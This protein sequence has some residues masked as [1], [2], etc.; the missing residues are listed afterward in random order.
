M[1]TPLIANEKKFSHFLY[2]IL[3]QVTTIRHLL[4]KK[5]ANK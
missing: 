5:K 1:T 4:I 3:S 2:T